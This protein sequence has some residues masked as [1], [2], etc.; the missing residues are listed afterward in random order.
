[1]LADW[2]EIRCKESAR[3]R[4]VVME[5]REIWEGRPLVISVNKLPRSALGAVT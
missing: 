1:M 2:G 3:S 5:F 4:V